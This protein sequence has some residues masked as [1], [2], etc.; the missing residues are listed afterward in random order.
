MDIDLRICPSPS[1]KKL[2]LE[3]ASPHIP[4]LLFVPI[5]SYSFC[6]ISWV[7][8]DPMGSYPENLDQTTFF[9]IAETEMKTK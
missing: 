1:Q 9:K 2:K 7:A 5:S 3:P 6:A 4:I 8:S